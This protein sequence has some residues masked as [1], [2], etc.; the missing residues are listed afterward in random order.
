MVTMALLIEILGHLMIAS[1][2]RRA[3]HT[4]KKGPRSCELSRL[5]ARLVARI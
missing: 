4:Q 2:D 1:D 3:D 5:A